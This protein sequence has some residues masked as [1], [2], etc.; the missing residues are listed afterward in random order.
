VYSKDEEE[1]AD[2][3]GGDEDAVEEEER[4]I[5]RS[6]EGLNRG[7]KRGNAQEKAVSIFAK[8]QSTEKT[9]PNLFER[10]PSSRFFELL[11]FLLHPSPAP[12]DAQHC[13]REMSVKTARKKEKK[14]K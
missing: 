9:T 6:V 7:R 11:R 3:E 8:K 14:N 4:R 13:R 10:D 12:D 5:W 1:V 2:F